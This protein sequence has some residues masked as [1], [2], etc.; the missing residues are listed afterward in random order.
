[1]SLKLIFP[2]QV[3]FGFLGVLGLVQM[4]VTVVLDQM[5]LNPCRHPA[6]WNAKYAPSLV[7][8]IASLFPKISKK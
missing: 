6:V 1:M 8:V 3:L 7:S 2:R 4:R 5:S